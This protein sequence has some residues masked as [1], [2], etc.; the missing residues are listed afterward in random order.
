IICLCVTG[1]RATG[2]YTLSLHDALPIWAG[3]HGAVG[4]RARGLDEAGVQRAVARHEQT[5]VAARAE[6]ADQGARL[7]VVAREVDG[8][9]TGGVDGGHGRAEVGVAD[10]DGLGADDEVAERVDDAAAQARAVLGR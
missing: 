7:G 9:R 5:V 2:F 8:V 6:L 1:S 10:L 4:G 3:E